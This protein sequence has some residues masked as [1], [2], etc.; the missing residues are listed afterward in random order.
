MTN[1][2]S[3][4]KPKR[5]PTEEVVLIEINYELLSIMRGRHNVRY[6]G[7]KCIKCKGKKKTFR[8]VLDSG[9]SVID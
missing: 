8:L 7:G 5:L 3:S 6:L 1:S 2:N 9:I 4:T